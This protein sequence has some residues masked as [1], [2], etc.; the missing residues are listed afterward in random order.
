MTGDV[1]Q[2]RLLV[3][4]VTDYAI[5]TLDV[6]G[7]VQ[8]WNAGAQRIKGWSADEIIGQHFSTFYTQPDK[9]RDHPAHEL[10]VATRDGR[11]EEE[12]WR[13]RSDGSQ[14]WANVVITALRD[15][16]GTLVGFGKVTRDLTARRLA[17]E[18]LRTNAAELRLVTADLEQFRLLVSSVRDYG[19]FM[20]DPGGCIRTWNEGAA[21]INGYSEAEII[22]RHFSIF[23]TDADRDRRHPQNELEIAAREGRFEEEGWRARKD[24]S[25]FWASVVITAVRDHNGILTGYGKVTRDLTERREADLALREA[26]A[27]LERFASAAAHDLS[28]P[29]HTIVGLAELLHRRHGEAIGPE[30]GEFIAHI[31]F[32]AERLRRMVDALLAYARASQQ[33]VARDPVP[34]TVAVGVVVDGLRARIEESGAVVVYDPETLPTVLGDQ[35]LLEAVLQNLLA[36]ALKFTDGGA[37]HVEITAAEEHGGWRITVADRGPGIAPADHERIFEPFQ[38]TPGGGAP[39][40]GLG[41][42]LSRRIVERHGGHIGVDSALGHGARFWFTLPRG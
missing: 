18:Q 3:D 14:F 31:R 12:G 2:L 35:P 5:F 19:I 11:F 28:E 42:A 38:R 22:G 21:N 29:L 30:A 10:E 26:N 7:H 40:A 16:S 20:L 9:D 4:A 39:G 34:L 41:L 17:E 36:N 6:E 25:Q 1:D 23:Y 32:A 27:E 24:G 33:E 8:S 15:S 37:P 13:V